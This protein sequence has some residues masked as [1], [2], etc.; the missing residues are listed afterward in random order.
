MEIPG[1]PGTKDTS[2]AKSGHLCHATSIQVTSVAMCWSIR[3][4]SRHV[5]HVT[6]FW[7]SQHRNGFSYTCSACKACD[8]SFKTGSADSE[9]HSAATG[10]EPD[11]KALADQMTKERLP[12]SPDDLRQIQ[13]SP[14]MLFE[15]KVGPSTHGQETSQQSGNS[16]LFSPLDICKLSKH[17]P[18]SRAMHFC[19][20]YTVG[21][22]RTFSF[23]ALKI[24]ISCSGQVVQQ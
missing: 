10:E 11:G 24:V 6:Q 8:T 19:F 3:M 2:S 17:I 13:K 22:A 16:E 9:V 21:T 4:L 15:S 5:T 1:H 20:C 12:T 14:D 18:R 23:K 7:P